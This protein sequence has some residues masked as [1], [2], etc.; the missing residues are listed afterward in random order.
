MTITILLYRVDAAGCDPQP[1]G[2]PLIR[3]WPGDVGPLVGDTLAPLVNDLGRL[4]VMQ[5]QW[6]PTLDDG[7]ELHVTAWGRE[8]VL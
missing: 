3:P 4:I 1:H 8:V 5:R 7:W 2:D 6:V